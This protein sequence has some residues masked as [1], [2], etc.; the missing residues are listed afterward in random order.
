MFKVEVIL[1]TYNGRD[2]IEE[3]LRSILWQSR[4]PDKITVLDDL[5][6][7]D[8]VSIAE[9]V[10]GDS[11]VYYQVLSNAE[12]I[13]Y[14]RNFASGV[15]LIENSDIVLFCDQDDFWLRNKVEAILEVFQHNIDVDVVLHDVMFA[16]ENLKPLGITK[17]SH[18]RRLGLTKKSFVQGS[19]MAVRTDYL[20]SIIPFDNSIGHD[21][22]ICR[23]AKKI[24]YLEEVLMLYRRHG[25]NTSQTYLNDLDTSP[26]SLLLKVSYLRFL[27]VLKRCLR[28]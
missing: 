4:V 13:G 20:R 28:F 16:N 17:M 2:Y 18:I 10:L 11:N 19:A 15:D 21:N 27:N 14:T 3:Q 6:N 23:K 26:M 8:T 9:R 12:N 22:Y 5:S 24:I 1:A 7:D 25:D